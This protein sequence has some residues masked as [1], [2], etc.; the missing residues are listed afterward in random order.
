MARD[1]HSQPCEDPVGDWEFF[2]W[3]MKNMRDMIPEGCS[4][5]QESLRLACVDWSKQYFGPEPRTIT[6]EPSILTPAF[7]AK[8]AEENRKRREREHSHFVKIAAM[9]NSIQELEHQYESKTNEIL[10]VD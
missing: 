4:T 7:V 10:P 3:R 6:K 1:Y 5:L 2:K 8:L 9:L